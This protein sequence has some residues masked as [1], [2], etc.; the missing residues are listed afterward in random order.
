MK[1]IKTIIDQNSTKEF[2][3]GNFIFALAS[4]GFALVI[5]ALYVVFGIINHSW[6]DPVQIILLVLAAVLIVLSIIMIV[7]HLKAMNKMKGYVRTIIYDFLDDVISFEIYRDEEKIETGKIY[8]Q[9]FLDYKVSKHYVY[10]RLR[11]NTWL[12]INKEEELISFIKNKGIQKHKL[13]SS[14]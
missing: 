3:Q 2:I 14:R 5:V 6:T 1:Q 10:L 9:D 12:A 13:F 7:A 11:N 4:L 8:Y